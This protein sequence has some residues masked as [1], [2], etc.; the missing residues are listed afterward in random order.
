MKA[1][2]YV[3]AALAALWTVTPA[4]TADEPKLPADFI[5]LLPGEEV[6]LQV[7]AASTAEQ[8]FP[9]GV[10]KIGTTDAWK[11]TKGKGVKVCILDTGCDLNHPDLK[12]GIAMARDF[13]GSQSGPSD[14][15]GHGTHCAGSVGARGG[16]RGGI[17]GVAPECTFLIGKVLGDSGNGSTGGI[18]QGIDWATANGADVISMSLGGGHAANMQAA[19][20]R[21]VAA[22]VLVIAAAGNSGPGQNTVGYPGGYSSCVCIGATD[23]ND[24][25]ANFSSRGAALFVSGPGVNVRSCY[26][27]SRYATM[28]GTSMATPHLAG[29]AALWV[30]ANP[31]LP[32]TQRNAAFREAIKGTSIDLGPVGRDTAFGF[33]R[34]DLTKLIP[35][36]PVTPP[37]PV[38]GKSFLIT[39]ADL[40][41]DALLRLRASYPGATLKL[42]FK[43]P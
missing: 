43:Q 22:G 3:L 31:T 10:A 4:P 40:T 28:S 27:G 19:C 17:W 41:P 20:E 38:P 7:F 23:V 26:P 11:T 16:D 42:E 21:A 24:N 32:K 9:W 18:A 8:P 6:P 15:N 37:V 30:A 14:I 36:G 5:G 39:E 29:C 34:V 33:G 2:L 25:I 13:T 12:D 1:I 35:G